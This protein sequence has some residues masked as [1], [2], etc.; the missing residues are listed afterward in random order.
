[1]LA[2]TAYIH[3][4][5]RWLQPTIVNETSFRLTFDDTSYRFQKGRFWAAPGNVA[6][7]SESTFSLCNKLF[8]VGV[9]GSV[10]YQLAVNP[11]TSLTVEIQYRNNF[12]GDILV[13]A[14]IIHDGNRSKNATVLV[15]G[16]ETK[17]CVR[18]AP[19]NEAKV[20]VFYEKE[21][22]PVPEAAAAL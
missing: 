7:N 8:G 16:V 12:F 17:I 19:G 14:N 6:A 15:D 20:T 5:C 9:N 21:A 18:S 11:E 22:T 4:H 13:T 10:Q 1:M 3:V 2:C